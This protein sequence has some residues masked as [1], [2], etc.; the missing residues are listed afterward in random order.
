VPAWEAKKKIPYIGM[1]VK[2]V[3]EKTSIILI[4]SR[5]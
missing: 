5:G 3:I 1:E 2:L 4:C